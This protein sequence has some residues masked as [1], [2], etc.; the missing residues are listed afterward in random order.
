MANKIKFGIKN[1]HYAVATIAADG[2]ATYDTPVAIPGAVSISME[3]QGETTPFYADDI[4]YW[5]G[6]SNSGYEGDLEMAIIPDS[7]KKDILGF[8]E[9]SN[10]ILVEVTDPETIHFALLF[11]FAGDK[12]AIRH[13]LYNCTANRPSVSS[14]TKTE[15]VEPQTESTTITATSIYDATIEKNIVKASS[16]DATTSAA[17]DGWYTT[18]PVPAAESEEDT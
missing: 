16:G 13:C 7:F 6:Y 9:D 15:T 8:V 11:E 12:K 10:K 2:T 18:V 3:P 4:V 14:T 1:V 17:Y 5:T